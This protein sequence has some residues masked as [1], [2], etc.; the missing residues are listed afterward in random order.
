MIYLLERAMIAAELGN[1]PTKGSDGVAPTGST[2]DDSSSLEA[3]ANTDKGLRVGSGLANCRVAVIGAGSGGICAARYLSQAGVKKLVVYETGSKIG[4]LWCYDNDSGMSSAYR[5]LHINSP[6]DHTSFSDLPFDKEVQMFP[7]HRDMYLYFERYARKFD[8]YKYIRFNTRVVSVRKAAEFSKSSPIWEVETVDGG[9]EEFDRVIVA[10]GHLHHPME[11]ESFKA[12]GGEYFHSHY[13]K[14]PHPYVGKRICIVGV[15]NSALDIASDVCVNSEKTVIVARSGVLI[16][17]KMIF[18]VPF[19]DIIRRLYKPWIPSRF[20]HAVINLLVRLIHGDMEQYG[21][22]PLRA[23]THGTSNAVFVHHLAY[24]RIAVKHEIDRIEAKRIYFSDGTSDEFDVLVGATGYKIDL[25]FIDPAMLAPKDNALE[26]YLRIVPPYLPGLYF[27]GFLQ[28]A[29]SLPLALEH[30]MRWI[31][32][33][34]TG[35]IR[36]P[37]EQKMREAII[38]KQNWVQKT[39]KNSFRHQIEEDHA[40]YFAELRVPGAKKI[41]GYDIRI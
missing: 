22:R 39:F 15:G 30:Q 12:F 5:T 16:Q 25:P 14:Q 27:L 41:F 26:L 19:P 40:D 37:S 29:S 38:A 6:R 32:G 33:V 21:F 36:L 13:Y 7:D 2:L 20:R 1:P 11:V 35:V 9:V 31:V 34:E 23:R 4:G 24:N 17:P 18:G 28:I 8:I 10:T 3:M